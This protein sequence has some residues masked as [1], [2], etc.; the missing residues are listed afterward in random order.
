VIDALA[1]GGTDR[2]DLIV[3]V[4]PAF[5]Q[6][7]AEVLDDLEATADYWREALGRHAVLAEA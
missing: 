1:E 5:E 7:D 4:I 6:D 3:E 2:S